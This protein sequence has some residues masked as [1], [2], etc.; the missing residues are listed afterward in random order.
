MEADAARNDRQPTPMTLA[1]TETARDTEKVLRKVIGELQQAAPDYDQ[2]EP[3]LQQALRQH[4][5]ET[6]NLLKHVGAMQ[7]IECVGN[8]GGI[9]FYRVTFEHGTITWLIGLSPAGK[10]GAL[11]LR[12]MPVA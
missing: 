5:Q 8:Q 9:D 2:M 7:R 1:Q 6:V 10:I 4:L 3:A 12:P 11:V